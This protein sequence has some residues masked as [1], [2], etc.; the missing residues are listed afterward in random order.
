M[1]DSTPE[2][3]VSSRGVGRPFR[4]ARALRKSLPKCGRGSGSLAFPASSMTFSRHRPG[5]RGI[6]EARAG[7]RPKSEPASPHGLDLPFRA[8][9]HERGLALASP[10]SLE[11]RRKVPSIDMPSA[12]PLPGAEA[13]FGLTLPNARSRSV[14]VV[15]LH[16]DV[17]LRAAVAGLLHPAADHEVRRI[18]R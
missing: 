1:I 10:S 11:I 17:L 4:A 2:G 12:R 14:L 16:P 8:L 3:V 13:P 18:S 6:P 7:P 15:S 5:L 9:E